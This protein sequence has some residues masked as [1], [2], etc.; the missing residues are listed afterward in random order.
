MRHLV[1][2]DLAPIMRHHS[3]GFHDKDMLVVHETVSKDA[4]GLADI[5]GVAK[6]LAHRDYGIHG[7]TDLEGHKAWA[8]GLGRAV[9]YQAGG[10]NERSCGIEQVSWIPAL[11]QA[12]FLTHEQAFKHWMA[13]QRQLQATAQLIAAWHTNSPKDHPLEYSNGNEPG[14]T[15]HWNVSQTHQKSDGHWDCW[16]KHEGGYYP[17]LYVI[18]L[19]RQYADAGVSF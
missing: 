1:L 9:F 18:G 6:D 19:A 17:L 3:H 14:V 2:Y 16:P 4:A 13:R 11:I 5:T 12:K 10:V 7:M 8:R 15:S